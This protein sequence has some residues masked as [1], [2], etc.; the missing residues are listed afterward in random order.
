M[1]LK[2]VRESSGKSQ[3]VVATENG[4]ALSSYRKIESG[5]TRRPHITNV[6]GIASSI[7]ADPHTVDEFVETLAEYEVAKAGLSTV[8]QSN[9]ET[10]HYY[11]PAR[12]KAAFERE[13]NRRMGAL[14]AQANDEQVA[15][16]SSDEVVI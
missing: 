13:V 5:G 1:K 7:G 6:Y 14:A 15:A 3:Q 2:Q 4:M 9:V 10:G 12:F 11:S 16:Q 8:Q